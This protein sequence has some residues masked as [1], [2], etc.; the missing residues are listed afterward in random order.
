MLG[1]VKPILLGSSECM[2]S[3]YMRIVSS[4]VNNIPFA[5]YFH[6]VYFTGWMSEDDIR[7]T[8]VLLPSKG[9]SK[10]QC[11]PEVTLQNL[12]EFKGVTIPIMIKTE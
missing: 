9:Y 1:G 8:G 10:M 6:L 2:R 5:T 12:P 3:K 4:L 7:T 11:N